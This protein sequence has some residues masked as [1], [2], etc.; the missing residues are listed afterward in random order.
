MVARRGLG[1]SPDVWLLLRR[2]PATDELKR[3]QSN[4]AADMPAARLVWLAGLRW[5]IEQCFRD[6]K[7]FF[8]LTVPRTCLLVD[9]VLSHTG[10]PADRALA[11]VDYRWA[12]NA[13]ARRSHA[14]C[15]RKHC[16]H[17]F[18]QYEV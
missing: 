9:A 10:S 13:A 8:G 17:L 18:R 6:G 11:I 12:R 16:A 1:P 14:Q 5:P 15:R 3:Y 2:H 4:G 7:Q